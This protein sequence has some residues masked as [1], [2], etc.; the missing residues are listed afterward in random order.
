MVAF[1]WLVFIF[2]FCFCLVLAIAWRR[3]GTAG[4]N[5]EYRDMLLRGFDYQ[6]DEILRVVSKAEVT[7][8]EK[9]NY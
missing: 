2:C 4:E 5:M 1:L 9:G 3:K 7:I 8:R 6:V